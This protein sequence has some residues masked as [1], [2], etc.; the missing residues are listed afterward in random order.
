MDTYRMF[1]SSVTGVWLECKNTMKLGENS[2]R[3]QQLFPLSSSL[4]PLFI[5]TIGTD[6]EYI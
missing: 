5:A 1:S 6:I 4:N 2:T 3:Q